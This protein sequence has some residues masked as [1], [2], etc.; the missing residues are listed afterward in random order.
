MSRGADGRAAWI[1][2][3]STGEDAD[4]NEAEDSDADTRWRMTE[5]ALGSG[6]ESY[7]IKVGG[8]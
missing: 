5:G 1:V 4:R 8:C 2:P 3:E 7:D 6:D